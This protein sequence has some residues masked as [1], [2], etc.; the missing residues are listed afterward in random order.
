MNAPSGG[1]GNLGDAATECTNTYGQA[2]TYVLVDFFNVGPAIDTID[3]LNGV[4]NAVG[5][6]NVSTAASAPSSTSGA[7]RDESAPW[8]LA[9][10]LI[11][12]MA[13][14]A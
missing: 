10:A 9:A 4:T 7:T 5:R 8:A 6:T 11:A 12:A 14:V 2:P 13:L 1:T 3:T